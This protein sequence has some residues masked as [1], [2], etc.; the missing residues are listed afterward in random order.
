[1]RNG[2]LVVADGTKIW[3]L[4][5]KRHRINGPA[6]EYCDGYKAWYQHDKRHRIDGPAIIHTNRVNEWW[7]NDRKIGSDEE[8]T[9]WIKEN[10]ID[11]TLEEHQLA[12]KLT[13]S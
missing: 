2:L 8:I 3:Y 7:I 12:F 6:I 5:N 13:W 10:N 11:L 1:M 9:R 4:D